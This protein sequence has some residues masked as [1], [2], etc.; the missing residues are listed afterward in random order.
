MTKEKYFDKTKRIEDY[1]Q[2]ISSS[3][4][5]EVNRLVTI[6]KQRIVIQS[7]GLQ[8]IYSVIVQISF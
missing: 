4:D 8:I 3:F 1:T 5:S 2:V 7:K 6:S